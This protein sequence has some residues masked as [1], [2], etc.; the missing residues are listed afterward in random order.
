MIEYQIKG[1]V[2]VQCSPKLTISNHLVQF[3]AENAVKGLLWKCPRCPS[4]GLRL[5]R[6]WGTVRQR[7]DVQ[8]SCRNTHTYTW[9]YKNKSQHVQA[10][11][12][13]HSNQ[14]I[15]AS[16]DYNRYKLEVGTCLLFYQPVESN[17]SRLSST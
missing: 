8:T 11:T 6:H 7:P 12:E 13:T 4:A 14:Q 9:A 1:S 16:G 15:S 17:Q 5:R 2:L 10:M 3:W